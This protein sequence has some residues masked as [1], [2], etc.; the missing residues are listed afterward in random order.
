MSNI[1]VAFFIFPQPTWRPHIQPI[2]TQNGLNDADSRTDVPFA[3]KIETF[4]NPCPQG[5]ENRQ[6]LALF[7]TFG[8]LS[9]L[10][11]SGQSYKLYFLS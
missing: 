10:N 8:A 4:S 9:H 2:F 6:N 11:T 3:V 7:G 5:P 1:F